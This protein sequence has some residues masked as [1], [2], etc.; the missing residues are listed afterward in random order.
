MRTARIISILF[1]IACC[2]G[3][4]ASSRQAQTGRIAG[5]VLDV[6]G[7]RIA[8][9]TIKVE[10]EQSH[11]AGRS[12]SQGKF[13]LKLPSGVYQLTVEKPGF[14]KFQFPNFQVTTETCELVNI[15]LNVARPELPVKV[16]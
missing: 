11:M 2:T 10:N 12:D 14:K 8:G 7:S 5:L 13:E 4:V 16:K 9:A 3:L 15:H 6:N 1:V